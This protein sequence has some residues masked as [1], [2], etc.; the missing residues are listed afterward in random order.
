MELNIKVFD[1]HKF[2]FNKKRTL[3]P[4]R[5]LSRQEG[6]NYYRGRLNT[7]GIF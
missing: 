7:N 6:H 2:Y 5:G 4:R 1:L 3:C